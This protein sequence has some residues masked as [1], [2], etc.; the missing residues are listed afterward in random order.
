MGHLGEIRDQLVDRDRLRL[1]RLLAAIGEK[2]LGQLRAANRGI[3]GGREKFHRIAVVF[4][5]DLIDEHVEIAH[6]HAE[7]IVEVM[8]NA[9]GEL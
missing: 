1:Q 2:L 7:N 8:R 9:A 4:G 6:D 5:A 3:D